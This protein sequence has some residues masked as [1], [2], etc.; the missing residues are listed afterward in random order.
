MSELELVVFEYHFSDNKSILSGNL[1]LF[2]Q[3]RDCACWSMHRFG[4]LTN[5][6]FPVPKK[7][8]VL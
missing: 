4:D 5:T 2:V 8:G 6:G 3:K 1:C 7:L